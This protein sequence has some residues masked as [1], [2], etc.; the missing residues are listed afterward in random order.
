MESRGLASGSSASG[1]CALV[2]AQQSLAEPPVRRVRGARRRGLG[3]QRPERSL[4][5][6]SQQES[7]MAVT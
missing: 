4:A 3:Q 7:S 2:F 6:T 5:P 1:A